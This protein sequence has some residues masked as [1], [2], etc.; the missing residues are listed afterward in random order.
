VQLVVFTLGRDRYALPVERVR[1][2]IRHRV[3]AAGVI[4]LRDGL[5]PV[6]DIAARVGAGSLAGTEPR[7]VI[8]DVHGVAAGVM[9]DAVAAEAQARGEARRPD[10]GEA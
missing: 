6:R 3:P 9:V 1:E 10:Q 2:V 5:V 4:N 7:I 8:V